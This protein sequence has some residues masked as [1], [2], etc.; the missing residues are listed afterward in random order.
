MRGRTS[1]ADREEAGQY[2]ARAVEALNLD[3]PVILALPRGG[4]PVGFEVAKVLGAPLDILM[5]RKIGAPGHEEY[6]IGALVDGA[7]PQ[8]VVDEAMARMV[9]ASSEY[10]DRQVERE[11]AEI[12]RRRVLYRTGPPIALEGRTVVIVDDGIATGGTVRAALQG[13]AKARPARIVLAIPLA[14]RDV[15]PDLEALCDRVVCLASPEPFHAVGMHYRDFR[16]TEDAE[17][18]RL[19]AEARGWTKPGLDETRVS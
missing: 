14:P 13:L 9:G 16:Q 18:I 1:F 12:E 7:S 8:V 15:L 11:L 6:G 3:N 19:L 5:V 17:V 4:V 10:I 2:L